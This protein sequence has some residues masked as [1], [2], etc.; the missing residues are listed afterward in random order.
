[1]ISYSWFAPMLHRTKAKASKSIWVDFLESPNDTS[2]KQN[3][4]IWRHSMNYR[5]F[6]HLLEKTALISSTDVS[7]SPDVSTIF[8]VSN[9]FGLDSQHGFWSFFVC[10][11]AALIFAFFPI[12]TRPLSFFKTISVPDTFR[13]GLF[14]SH[15]FDL[16]D[17]NNWINC[18]RYAVE[19]STE[20]FNWN[21]VRTQ[22]HSFFS[23]SS[24]NSTYSTASHSPDL[25]FEWTT[26]WFSADCKLYFNWMTSASWNWTTDNYFK[27]KS[28]IVIEILWHRM[29]WLWASKSQYLPQVDW[30]SRQLTIE[31]SPNLWNQMEDAS[32]LIH[33]NWIQSQE[34]HYFG[35]DHTDNLLLGL[36]RVR[37]AEKTTINEV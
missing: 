12:P 25:L 31:L 7:S 15:T 5:F 10:W 23:S 16:V 28:S 20:Y 24:L 13:I 19:F 14:V 34:L 21:C 2:E 9:S 30:S 37:C 32:L 33:S 18:S 8:N 29:L 6:R 17:C 11:T 27:D 22:I 3:Y 1:M 35:P 4:W 26:N 36:S